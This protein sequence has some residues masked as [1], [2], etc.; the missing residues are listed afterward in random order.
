MDMVYTDNPLQNISDSKDAT[1]NVDTH[2]RVY[3]L[4][5]ENADLKTENTDLKTENT[6]LK[7]RE[8]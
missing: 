7:N 2:S 8:Y 1:S 5:T 6:D 4:E 3:E